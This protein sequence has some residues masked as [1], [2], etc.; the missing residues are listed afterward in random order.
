LFASQILGYISEKFGSGYFWEKPE[1]GTYLKE[2]V[3]APGKTLPWPEMVKQASGEE[4][5]ARH[6]VQRYLQGND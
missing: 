3:F 5:S 4:L 2:K 6:F 1:I